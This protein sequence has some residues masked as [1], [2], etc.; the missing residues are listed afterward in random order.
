MRAGDLVGST[1]LALTNAAAEVGGD[2]R[3]VIAFSCLGRHYESRTTDTRE[4]LGQ[5]YDRTPL[6]GFHSLGEQKGPLLVNHTLT[7]LALGADRG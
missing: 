7:G 3:A 6:V 5:L 2:L 1:K 4:A